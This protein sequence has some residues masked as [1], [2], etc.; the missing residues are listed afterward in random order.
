[1]SERNGCSKQKRKREK[2]FF[3]R[4]AI[5]PNIRSMI[6]LWRRRLALKP[7]QRSR[8][9]SEKASVSLRL[10]L[11]LAAVKASVRADLAT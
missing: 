3:E 4:C 8:K 1:M 10:S 2:D 5:H 7:T 9:M 6:T 11:L